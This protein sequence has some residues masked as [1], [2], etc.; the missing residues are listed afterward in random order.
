MSSGKVKRQGGGVEVGGGELG[1]RLLSLEGVEC[2][3]VEGGT[4][5]EKS[6]MGE[7]ERV[8]ALISADNSSNRGFLTMEGE[9]RA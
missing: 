9:S 6:R 4:S 2:R 7:G 5:Q 1:G 8:Y 3:E